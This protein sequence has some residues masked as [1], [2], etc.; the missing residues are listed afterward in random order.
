MDAC[1]FHTFLNALFDE[2]TCKRK[3][4]DGPLTSSISCGQTNEL[5]VFEWFQL[6]LFVE[7]NWSDGTCEAP[8]YLHRVFHQ[9]V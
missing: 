9:A 2:G 6:W 1:V 4:N 7:L 8:L 5:F 3:T